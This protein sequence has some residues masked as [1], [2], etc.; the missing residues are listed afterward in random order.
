MRPT[1]S[2]AAFPSLSG[3]CNPSPCNVL[4]YLHAHGTFRYDFTVLSSCRN[5]ILIDEYGMMKLSSICDELALFFSSLQ[6]LCI[7]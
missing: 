1:S 5:L 7:F 4:P 6:K 2:E 3:T